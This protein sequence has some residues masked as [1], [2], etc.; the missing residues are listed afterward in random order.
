MKVPFETVARLLEEGSREELRQLLDRVGADSLR[1]WFLRHGA[2]VL[3]RR[4]RAFWAEV[5][6]GRP[7][8]SSELSRQ[9]WPL[10]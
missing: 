2:R 1:D 10:A 7:L 9:L 8:E 3:S 5:W 4:S 6:L